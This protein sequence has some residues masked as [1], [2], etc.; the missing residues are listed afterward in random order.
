MSGGES[1]EMIGKQEDEICGLRAWMGKHIEHNPIANGWLMEFGDTADWF[2]LESETQ[3][4]E[5]T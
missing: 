4:K 3:P 2:V 5:K 1:P